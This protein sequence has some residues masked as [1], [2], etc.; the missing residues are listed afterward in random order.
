M[1]GPDSTSEGMLPPVEQS[2]NEYR[3]PFPQTTE[4]T[5]TETGGPTHEGPYRGAI[6]FLMPLGTPVLAPLDGRVVRVIDTNERY[7][8]SEQFVGNLN[9]I[10][11]SHPNGEF[12][13][14]AHLAK[15][16][17]AVKIGDVV[18]AGQQIAVTGTSGYM[19]EPHLHLLVF[20]LEQ[21]EH[22]FRGLDPRFKE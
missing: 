4:V 8:P 2:R 7:G 21:D 6:D 11:M 18:R 9:Y 1:T 10:T 3:K 22:G 16:S 13:E 14:V 20:R 12:S 19:T 17:S 5:G 15:G